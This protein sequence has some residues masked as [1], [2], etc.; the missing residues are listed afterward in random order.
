MTVADFTGAWAKFRWAEKHLSALEGEVRAYIESEPVVRDPKPNSNGTS[1]DFYYRFVKPLPE[2][3]DLFLGD[4]V[5]NF[6]SVLDHIAMALAIHNGVDPSNSSIYFPICVK[7]QHFFGTKCVGSFEGDAPWKS[8]RRKVQDL[9]LDAQ[10]FVEKMQPYH[11]GNESWVLPELQY[12]DNRDKHRRLLTHNFQQLAQFA[13]AVPGVTFE[14]VKS[15]RVE[16]G[17]HFATVHYAPGYSSV[18]V[19]PALLLGVTVERA[20]GF[21]FLIIP[22]YLRSNLQDVVR[23]IITEAE[24]RF[25]AWSNLA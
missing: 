14:Y 8:G 2:D 19:K 17:A 13:S 10:T 3:L 24:S 12:L 15:T 6:R 25:G 5:H 11:G 23:G 7:P 1:E 22:D 18:K 9:S 16:D 4:C 20:N 21:G